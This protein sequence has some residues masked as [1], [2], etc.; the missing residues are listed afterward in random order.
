MQ[1]KVVKVEFQH[2]RRKPSNG[3]KKKPQLNEDLPKDASTKGRRA[4]MFD[5]NS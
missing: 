2:W 3:I 4:Y 1:P 5:E